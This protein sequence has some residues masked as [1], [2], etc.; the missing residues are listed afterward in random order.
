MRCVLFDLDNTLVEIPDTYHFF[1][2]L[3]IKVIQDDYRLPVPAQ[4]SRDT[5]WRSGKDYIPILKGWGVADPSDFWRRFDEYDFHKRK[6]YIKA[7]R[8]RLYPDTLSA[9]IGLKQL[10]MALG[11]VSNT[12]TPIVEYELNAFNLSGYFSVIIGLGETQELCKPEPDGLLEAI[13]R[14]QCSYGH[15][16]FVGD[17]RVDLIAGKRANIKNVLIDR[18][19]SKNYASDE[20]AESDFIHIHD[21]RDII[22]VV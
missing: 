4:E 5:L 3:I 7:G 17:S 2:D 6:E 18:N 10:G 1:D 15:A 12:T 19:N 16:V 8:I 20:I 11:I 9:L 13:R 14:L 22:K 21:L